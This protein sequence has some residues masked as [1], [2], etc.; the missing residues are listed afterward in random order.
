LQNGIFITGTDTGV[1]KTVI[2]AALAYAC[3]QKK[4]DFGYIKPME[5]GVLNREYLNT[6][7]DAALVK[8]AGSLP[9]A[10]EEIVPFTF[11]EP[12]APR[13]AARR[14]GIKITRERLI[15]SVK[16]RINPNRLTIVEGAGG[17]MAPLCENFLVLDLIRELK[18]PCLIVCRTALGSVNHTLLTITCLRRA[19]MEPV[20]IIANNTC[21]SG[22]AEEAFKDQVTEFTPV[23]ILG[24]MP[25]IVNFQPGFQDW[26]KLANHIDITTLLNRINFPSP[27][28]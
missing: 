9:E 21:G 20:G 28:E 1:G 4:L 23:P 19:G 15:N 13:L 8:K 5:S 16:E 2:A 22:I 6:A 10:L 12:L 7:S 27:P 25:F 3:R 24:E 18:F 11:S 14:A 26:S 17:L